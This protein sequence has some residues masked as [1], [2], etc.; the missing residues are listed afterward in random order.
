MGGFGGEGGTEKKYNL[1][2]SVN[3]MNLLNHANFAPP[4]GD[5]SSPFFGQSNAIVYG[6]GNRPGGG[7]G[8]DTPPGGNRRIELMLRFSF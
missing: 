5:I 7:G 2:L 1:T 8:G 3:A 4:V 6:F